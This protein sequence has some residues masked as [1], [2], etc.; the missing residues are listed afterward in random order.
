MCHLGHRGEKN[1]K[2]GSVDMKIFF[3]FV[4]RIEYEVCHIKTG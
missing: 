1:I 2:N 3:M 4:W